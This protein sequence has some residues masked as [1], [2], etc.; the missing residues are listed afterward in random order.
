M[1]ICRSLGN[2]HFVSPAGSRSLLRGSCM[3][4]HRTGMF[5]GR[6]NQSVTVGPGRSSV[7]AELISQFRR[8]VC[9][10]QSM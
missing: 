7:T 9:P 3:I 6:R 1:V 10:C 4:A 2:C 8:T 5:P